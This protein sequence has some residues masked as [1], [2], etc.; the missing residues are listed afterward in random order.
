ME[1]IIDRLARASLDNTKLTIIMGDWN[2]RHPEWDDGVVMT[3]PRTRETLGWVKGNGFTLCNEPNIPTRE[4]SMG[5]ALVIDLTFKNAAAN[6]TNVLTGH[7]VDMST[8]ILSDHHAL[9]FHIGDPN[10]VVYNE[11]SNNLNWKHATEE[12]FHEAIE[13]QLEKEKDKHSNLVSHILNADRITT[14][15][16]E[17]DRTMDWIQ[18]V[19]EWAAVKAVPECRVCNKSKPWWTPKLTTA[20]KDLHQET[21]SGAPCRAYR[22]VIVS[23]R[24]RCH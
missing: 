6:G 12:E 5:H 19:L 1:W 15:P 24:A 20:Y 4:N 11:L 14:M 21:M 13:E 10:E 3:C 17:L 2:M 16:T 9:V 8:G 22:E 18:L 7:H 23:A